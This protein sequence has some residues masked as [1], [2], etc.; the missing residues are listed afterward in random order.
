MPMPVV[1][2]SESTVASYGTIGHLYEMTLRRMG[3]SCVR[4]PY[5]VVGRPRVP[6]G[7]IVL[8]N[9]LGFRFTPIRGA[10]NVAVPF[11]EWSGYPAAWSARLNR[12]DAVWA[13]SLH[14]RDL[15]GRSGVTVPIHFAPPALDLESG[16]SRRPGPRRAAHRPFR[17]LFVG[18][19]HFRKG[20]HLLIEGFRRL[21]AEGRPA[22]LT[23]KTSRDCAWTVPDRDIRLIAARWSRRRLLHLYRSHDAFVSAS[24][25]EGLGLG[26]AEAILAGVPVATNRWGGHRSLLTAGGFHPISYRETPQPFCSRPDFFTSGQRC[27]LSTP[28]QVARAMA[29][30]MDASPTARARQTTLAE[31]FL[32]GRFGFDPVSRRLRALI[33]AYE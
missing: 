29:A 17:F 16:P 30:A 31:R 12:F 33:D 19:P 10:I 9:T 2:L 25:G 5:P 14:V 8:H 6:R 28:A 15:L 24:L 23:I 13:A 4:A 26:V 7:A 27:A 18:E 32:R 22:T 11:H 21:R 20:H 1:I 3:I